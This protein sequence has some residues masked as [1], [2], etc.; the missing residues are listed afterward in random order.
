M[1]TAIKFKKEKFDIHFVMKSDRFPNDQIGVL[2]RYKL[3]R[4]KT[5]NKPF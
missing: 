1:N 4:H 3:L 2:E 5:C